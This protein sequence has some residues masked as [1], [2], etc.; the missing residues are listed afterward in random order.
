MK[1]TTLFNSPLELGVRMVFLL[2]AL[3]P[4]KADLQHLI[5]LDYAVIYSADLGGPE[6]LHAP[7]PLRGA[8][9]LSRRELIEE[10]LYLMSSRGLIDITATEHGIQYSAG[11]NA[12]SLA[13]IIGGKYADLLFSRCEWVAKRFSSLDLREIEMEFGIRGAK[14]GA[15]FVGA[16]NVGGLV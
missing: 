1:M 14:W 5:Y 4:R 6:S 8:E 16:D 15:H 13:G 9:F 3:S 12:A 2:L 11:E 7:V 10:G